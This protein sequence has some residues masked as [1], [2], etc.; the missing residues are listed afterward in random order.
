MFVVSLPAGPSAGG[1]NGQPSIHL[2]HASTLSYRT[3]DRGSRTVA[4][5]GATVGELG[6]VLPAA[7]HCELLLAVGVGEA[8][9]RSIHAVPQRVAIERLRAVSEAWQRRGDV[10]IVGR[11]LVSVLGELA[12]VGNAAAFD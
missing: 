2:H 9:S 10:T 6:A 7:H 11:R 4:A 8:A 3:P 5:S 12:A 1:L